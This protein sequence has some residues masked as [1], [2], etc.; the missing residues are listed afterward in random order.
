[1]NLPPTL[2]YNPGAFLDRVPDTLAREVKTYFVVERATRLVLP[3]RYGISTPLGVSGF[4]IAQPDEDCA[5]LSAFDAHKVVSWAEVCRQYVDARPRLLAEY[6]AALARAR[7]KW[8]ANSPE[9]AA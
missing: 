4:W 7:M 8:R 5:L 3:V 9:K 6:P 1:M 2:P